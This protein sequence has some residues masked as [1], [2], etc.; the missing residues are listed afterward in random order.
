MKTIIIAEIGVNHNGS[1]KKAL[2][3]IDAAKHAG[4]DVVKFQTAIPQNVMLKDAKKAKYQR[5]DMHDNEFQI[6]MAKKFI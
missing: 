3:L 1:K 6:E 2:K 5:Q 4:A